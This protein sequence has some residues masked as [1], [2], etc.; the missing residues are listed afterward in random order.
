MDFQLSS[1]ASYMLLF[2]FY[3][4]G[5][6]SIY[7]TTLSFVI[8]HGVLLTTHVLA[9]S[10]GAKHQACDDMYPLHAGSAQTSVPP[11]ILTVNKD[12]YTCGGNISG[13]VICS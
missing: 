1:I 8:L 7:S 12:N 3:I 11:Y 9:A 2:F 6:V 5:I 10:N 4:T 13:A